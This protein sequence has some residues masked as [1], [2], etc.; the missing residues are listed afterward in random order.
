MFQMNAPPQ[1]SGKK[2][3]YVVVKLYGVMSQMSIF[4]DNVTKTLNR[5]RNVSTS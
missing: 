4:T 1:Y 5:T 3:Q 2:G